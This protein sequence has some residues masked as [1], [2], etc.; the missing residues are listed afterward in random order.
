MYIC[1]HTFWRGISRSKIINSDAQRPRTRNREF[2]F[3]IVNLL[4]ICLHCCSNI[5]R[6][7]GLGFRRS[8]AEILPTS[9]PELPRQL[10]DL[11]NNQKSLNTYMSCFKH[12]EIE[13]PYIAFLE[14]FNPLIRFKKSFI[15][16]NFGDVLTKLGVSR[17]FQPA[18]YTVFHEESESK[19]QNT[20]LLQGNIKKSVS[21]FYCLIIHQKV[22]FIFAY[23]PFLG[24]SVYNISSQCVFHQFYGLS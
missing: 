21:N 2:R 23:I 1:I 24:G 13:K 5:T 22:P 15:K 4:I 8:I 19:V 9:L 17:R 18:I 16:T 6:H 7:H 12:I 11:R 20:Q 3:L 14:A 10:R